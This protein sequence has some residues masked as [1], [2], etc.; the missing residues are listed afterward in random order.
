MGCLLAV[1]ALLLPRGTLFVL[2]LFTDELTQAFD[3]FVVGFLGFLVLPYTTVFYALAYSP[4]P[5]VEGL[6]WFLV[7]F[8]FLVDINTHA[9]AGR[10]GTRRA[11]RDA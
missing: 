11:A 10:I 7:A 8:G 4:G 1:V 9:Q 5:G 2:W 6:G 3:S